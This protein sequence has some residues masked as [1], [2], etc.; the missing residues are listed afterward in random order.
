MRIN[1]DREDIY[2]ETLK[3]FWNFC[4]QKCDKICTVNTRDAH[5]TVPEF[6]RLENEVFKQFLSE[7]NRMD[8]TYYRSESKDVAESMR[9][10]KI[11]FQY[12][13]IF[14]FFQGC[15]PEEEINNR[16]ERNFSKYTLI[17][18]DV[19]F[20]SHCTKSIT[21]MELFYF[22][23]NEDIKDGFYNMYNMF[24]NVLISDEIYLE[25][26]AFFRGK[27]VLLSICS[28][29][30]MATLEITEEEYEEFKKLN[31]SHIDIS[32]M[33][34]FD[35]CEKEWEDSEVT[36]VEHRAQ[37]GGI[38]GY[39]FMLSLHPLR[40]YEEKEELYT[41]YKDK[42][43]TTLIPVEQ[44]IKALKERY[45]LEHRDTE[46]YVKVTRHTILSN[47]S[48]ARYIPESR[49]M[50]IEVYQII[51]DEKSE[52]LYRVQQ[53]EYE[54]LEGKK[55]NGYYSYESIPYSK[56][57]IIIG[58]EYNSYYIWVEG[59]ESLKDEIILLRGLDESELRKIHLVERYVDALMNKKDEE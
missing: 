37:I 14:H 38:H 58:V 3:K 36:C 56:N 25:D 51:E 21:P 19:A 55:A 27:Q 11:L 45:T 31:I 46:D 41:Q 54:I 4:F 9:K 47:T 26:L 42:L 12:N 6:M 29:E 23:I 8:D 10:S 7:Y 34:W 50:K 20:E 2:G 48:L 43:N 24:S 15:Y 16:I 39:D 59:S 13:N 30:Q 17:E 1:M 22:Q 18:R 28:H 49:E 32:N 33:W 44:L 40:R 57:P 5:F 53:R 35:E 52:K